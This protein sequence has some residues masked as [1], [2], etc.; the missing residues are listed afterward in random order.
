[1]ST[2]RTSSGQMDSQDPGQ[3]VPNFEA[4]LRVTG[5]TY[6]HHLTP[7]SGFF[8]SPATPPAW[9]LVNP[10][11]STWPRDPQC[12]THAPAADSQ[13]ASHQPSSLR[14]DT[15]RPWYHLQIHFPDCGAQTAGPAACPKQVAAP[16]YPDKPA[17]G[18]AI[19]PL[20]QLF[21]PTDQ[22]PDCSWGTLGGNPHEA[23]KSSYTVNLADRPHQSLTR[24][25]EEAAQSPSHLP[26]GPSRLPPPPA[27]LCPSAPSTRMRG[28]PQGAHTQD[29]KRQLPAGAAPPGN[30]RYRRPRRPHHSCNTLTTTAPPPSARAGVFQAPPEQ[31]VSLPTAHG[32][33][34][35]S[36]SHAAFWDW[37]PQSQQPISNAVHGQHAGGFR[38]TSA[39]RNPEQAPGQMLAQQLPPRPCPVLPAEG[40]MA[41]PVTDVGNLPDNVKLEFQVS[42]ILFAG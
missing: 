10:C 36:P 19:E 28:I 30:P 4:G 14:S 39:G 13:A 23:A 20:G 27:K 40:A 41:T 7:S 9:P 15:T 16:S 31:P 18:L 3:L 2:S 33:H 6:C 25:R 11:L 17:K 29:T 12:R 5:N 37:A 38:S 42:C 32:V 22:L 35:E 21:P 1:M 34:H 8:H 26:Q 24:I